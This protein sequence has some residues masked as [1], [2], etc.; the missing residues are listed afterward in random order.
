MNGYF[1]RQ[2]ADYVE[3]HRDRWNCAMHVFGIIFLFLAAV[4]P[5]SFRSVAI[6]DGL[7]SAATIAVLPV[8]IYWFL[9]DAA[10]GTAILG[11]A[12]LLLSA[13]AKI[14]THVSVAGVWSIVAVL[15]VIGV[16]LQVVGHR[17][18]EGRQPALLDNPTHLLL[19]PMFVMAKFFT[20]LGFRRDLA[21]IIQ[22]PPGKA[23]HGSL[24]GSGKFQRGPNRHS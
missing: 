17:V 21:V 15:I 3:Y 11:A 14:V 1:R 16:T 7:I 5:L 4:L 12:V 2:L 13:A 22:E 24:P 19:G 8:L 18:F 23:P 6:F 9:L 20:A 10:L